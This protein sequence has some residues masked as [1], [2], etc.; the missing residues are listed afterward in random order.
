VLLNT[1]ADGLMIGRAAQ[2]R[3]WIFREIRHYLDHGDLLLPPEVEEIR[4]L[5]IEHLIDHCAFHGEFAG[6]RTARKHLGWYAAGLVEGA[7]FR[8]EVNRLESSA[9]Q[10]AAVNRFFDRLAALGRRL[11]YAPSPCAAAPWVEEALAA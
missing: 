2:G 6:V 3:P 11:K 5:V 4:G 10:I 1:G 7:A 8:N 9:A